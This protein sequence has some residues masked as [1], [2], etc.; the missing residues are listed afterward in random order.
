MSRSCCGTIPSN[1]PT[2][3]D[4][5]PPLHS[6]DREDRHRPERPGHGI[7]G[8]VELV[9]H[10]IGSIEGVDHAHVRIEGG[11]AP[12]QMAVPTAAL[13]LANAILISRESAPKDMC[14]T[15]IGVA[16]TRGWRAAGP[17]TVSVRTGSS[18]FR[19]MTFRTDDP[20]SRGQYTSS[21]R[22]RYGLS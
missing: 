3:T 10:R 13:P 21:H 12:E 18:S 19:G 9:E 22:T 4:L 6:D 7:R 2:R 11:P 5:H 14:E 1:P 20:A 8:L 17:I 16:R 15:I